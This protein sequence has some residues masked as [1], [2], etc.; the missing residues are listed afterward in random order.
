MADSSLP[1]NQVQL[2]LGEVMRATGGVLLGD[3]NAS[4]RGVSTDSRADLSG[5][6]FVALVGE[7]FDAHDFVEQAR[8]RGAVA[9]L[10]EREVTCDL[11]TIRVPSTLGALGALG[12]L[13]RRAWGG[14]V[15]AVA[16]SAGKTTTRAALSALLEAAEPGLVH[17]ARG[18]FNNLIGVPLVL[19]SLG[20]RERLAVVELGTNQR[21]EV[22]TLTQ[23]A[24]PDVGIL[25]LIGYEHTEGLGDLDGV[26]AE[27]AALFAGV[28]VAIGNVDD[29][30]VARQLTRAAGRRVSYGKRADADYRLRVLGLSS[31]GS[32]LE[33]TR[34]VAKREVTT[35]FRT[36]TL[37]DAGAYAACAA[38]AAVETLLGREL[39][40]ATMQAAFA[41]ATASEAGRLCPVELTGGILLLDDTYNANPESVVSSLELAR[42]LAEQRGV[43]LV[44][45]LGEMRELGALSVG[46]HRQVG[47]AAAARRPALLITVGGDAR[48]LAEAAAER[49]VPGEFAEDSDAAAELLLARLQGPSVILVKASRG[50][51]AEKVVSR[52][53]SAKGRAA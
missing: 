24:A 15:I 43:P 10:V 4:V 23:M 44:L 37:G 34:R 9:L 8:A 3:P 16:G 39:P 53:I 29:E 19:L 27:E 41:S 14:K 42:Q 28:S 25:T 22:A 36:S 46:L 32:E 2:T 1:T 18:N 26:E 21:G 11:P 47:E 7:R 49:G 40:A 48:A 31:R 17:Y 50:V 51:H 5:A 35:S 52:L 20:E 33:V 13:R 6:L 45:V 12:A 30:R 38:L